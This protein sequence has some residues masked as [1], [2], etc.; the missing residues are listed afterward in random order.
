MPINKS[1]YQNSLL[2]AGDSAN[3]AFKGIRARNIGA[4]T[5]VLEYVIKQGDRLDL[6]ALYFYNDSSKWWRLL[7]AN[8]NIM[9]AADLTLEG[10]VGST[11]QVPR[12]NEEGTA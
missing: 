12:L 1:R 4:A 5:E 6:L 8:S 2:F 3:P 9:F 11:I 7:D 10:Q